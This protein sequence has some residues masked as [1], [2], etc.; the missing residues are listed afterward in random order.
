MPSAILSVAA[1]ALAGL[2]ADAAA[3]RMSDQRATATTGI[4]ACA[5]GAAVALGMAAHPPHAWHGRLMP[6][7]A[8]GWILVSDLDLRTRSVHDL[9]ALGLALV[10][11]AAAALDHQL[12][13][14]AAGGVAVAGL[15]AAMNAVAVAA[16]GRAWPVAAAA[17]VGCGVGGIAWQ[18]MWRRTA[19][20]PWSG[21]LDPRAVGALLLAAGPPIL[22]WMLRRMAGRWEGELIGWGDVMLVGVMGLWFGIRWVWTPLLVGIAVSAALGGARWLAVTWA[23]GE[24]P[25]LREA[26]PTV[27]GLMVGAL[28]GVL[29]PPWR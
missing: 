26:Q 22:A 14:A 15:L 1:G 27:P 25:W 18:V 29:A 10:A 11:L 9:H 7:W 17:A 6:L 12:L 5:V 23:S 20:L 19:A 4:A 28:L 3:A 2:A 13:V 24:V 8:W 21:P 16:P